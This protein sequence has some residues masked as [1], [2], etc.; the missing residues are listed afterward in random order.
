MQKLDIPAGIL[1][2]ICNDLLEQIHIQSS[3]TGETEQDS[4]WIEQFHRQQIH[5]LVR[6]GSLFNL[7]MGGSQFGWV[8]D[9]QIVGLRSIPQLA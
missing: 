1:R 6:P 5:I 9:D 7:R 4:A 3:R 8:E 2:R